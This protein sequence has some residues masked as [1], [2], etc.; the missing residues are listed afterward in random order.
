MST[1][2]NISKNYWFRAKR[3]GWGWS[4]PLTW[5]GW[6][7]FIMY[8]GSVAAGIY[9]FPPEK[10]M[11]IFIC[12]IVILSLMF[13]AICWIKGEPPRWRWGKDKDAE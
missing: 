13:I 5:Q 12:L 8:I 7:I 4:L 9:I 1:K 11:V 2:N 3:Y 6:I 10:N